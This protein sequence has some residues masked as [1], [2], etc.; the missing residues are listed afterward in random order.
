MTTWIWGF[1]EKMGIKVWLIINYN[2][3][4]VGNNFHWYFNQ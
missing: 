4:T 2:L 3:P 1:I